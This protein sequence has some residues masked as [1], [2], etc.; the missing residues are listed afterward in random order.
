MPLILRKVVKQHKAMFRS[1]LPLIFIL[2]AGSCSNPEDTPVQVPVKA[3]S[4]QTAVV[5]LPS[6]YSFKTFVNVDSAGI[7]HGF[8]YD[9]YDNDKRLIHQLSIPGEPGIDGFVSEEEAQRVAALVVEKMKTGGGFP[10]ISHTELLDLG[11][12]LKTK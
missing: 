5:P 9:I 6:N 3:D 1:I 11:I 10:T 12:T 7:N 2:F 8:G 4:V